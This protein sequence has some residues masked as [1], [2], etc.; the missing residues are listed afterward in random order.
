MSRR[1]AALIL[2]GL[3]TAVTVAAQGRSNP[4]GSI[5]PLHGPLPTGSI[6]TIS[7]PT[8]GL[9]LPRIGL[10]QVPG[11]ARRP[12]L[13]G[14]SRGHRAAVIPVFPGYV[15]Y[16]DMWEM[17]PPAPE[18]APDVSLAPKPPANPTGELALQVEPSSAHVFI[19]GYYMGMPGDFLG[20]FALEAG[21]H[22]LKI[23]APGYETI[24]LP[25]RV[26]PDQT[27]TYSQS[28]SRLP[29]RGEEPHPAPAAPVAPSRKTF[30]M[31]PG[32]YFGDV[33]PADAGLPASC[34]Q[35]RSVTLQH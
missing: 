1:L 16:S 21:A 34:D 18:V 10:P 19:D 24:E 6:P 2:L 12:P 33:P 32:C 15:G 25:F 30:Y 26:T 28:L 35:Q 29:G 5:P 20:P 27:T 8:I 4:T 23:D 3:G 9:P 7:Q 14:A 31:I 22:T 17:W 13:R 11:G